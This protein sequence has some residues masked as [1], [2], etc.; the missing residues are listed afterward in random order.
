[1]TASK[2]LLTLGVASVLGVAYPT[3]ARAAVPAPHTVS[4]PA[5]AL[6]VD[7]SGYLAHDTKYAVLMSR[8]ARP[9]A[10]VRVL[11]GAGHRVATARLTRRSAWSKAYPYIYQAT[12]SALTRSGHYRLALAGTGVRSPR[13]AVTS[14]AGIWTRVLH[15]GVRFD[16]VQRDGKHVIGS[17]L[18]R[19]PSHLNDAHA[20]VYARPRFQRGSD[21]IIGRGLK[22]IGGPVD[23]AGG[24][25]DAGDYLKFTHSTAYADVLLFTAMRDLGRAAPAALAPEARHGLAWLTKMW[26]AKHKT[27]LLQVGI[28]SGNAGGTFYGDH[29]GWRLPQ[30]DDGNH[31]HAWRYVAHRPVFRAAAPGHKISPNLVGRTSAAF[32]LAA[33]TDAR[34]P[35]RAHREL[36]LAR[37]LYA[38]ADTASPP[39]PLVTALPNAFYP[40]STWH[41]DMELGAVEIVRASRLLHLRAARYLAQAARWAHDY[42]RSDTGD[43]FNLY[44]VSALAHRD[45]LRSMGD[46]HLAISRRALIADL[47]RQLAGAQR[48]AA[49]D[50]FGAGV[51]DTEFDVDSHTLGLVATEGWYTNVTGD[52]SFDALAARLR[53]WVFGRNAWGTSFMVG[54]GTRFPHCMQHQVANLVGS[55]NGKPPLALG[56]VV[57]G[58]NGA[59]QFQ[60]GLGGFQDGMVHCAAGPRRFNGS[61]SIYLDDVRAWQTDEPALDMT[62]A[63]IIAAASQLTRK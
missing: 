7:Q 62:G 40:E 33:Q 45:M 24:W 6:R 20:S 32:A 2:R 41:D 49:R 34:N 26:R 52:H 31:A 54:I 63:A 17:V 56:A 4:R 15:Y 5:A 22:K 13:F 16:Q 25:F 58:P 36:A 38:M 47:H 30:R 37:S 50:P 48:R 60:G 35:R 29:D 12:F 23:V 39:R 44:D 11:D 55:T 18:R 43:T 14:A 21:V 46:R 61:G 53:G 57:N 19:K 1:M 27:L 3:G 28:G 51:D 9:H 8:T 59:G 42:V 10:V